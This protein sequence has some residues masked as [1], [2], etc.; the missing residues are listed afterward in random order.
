MF[1]EGRHM[2]GMEKRILEMSGCMSIKLTNLKKNG[3]GDLQIGT[4][5]FPFEHLHKYTCNVSAERLNGAVRRT[6][7]RYL[8]PEPIVRNGDGYEQI[9]ISTERL[10]ISVFLRKKDAKKLFFTICENCSG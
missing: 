4:D 3:S 7:V 10:Q 8:F 2:T 9:S 1:I 6:H 5:S